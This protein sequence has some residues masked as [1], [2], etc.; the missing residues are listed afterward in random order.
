MRVGVVERLDFGFRVAS[1]SSIG[2]DI[3]WNI[4]QS[5]SFDLAIDPSIQYAH[6]EGGEPGSD[7]LPEWSIDVLRANGVLLFGINA[8]SVTFMPTLGIAYTETAGT[9]GTLTDFQA[10]QTSSGAAARVGLGLNIRVSQKF[11]IQPEFTVL[12]PIERGGDEG[13]IY[14]VGVGFSFGKLPIY[15]QEAAPPATAPG[16]PA[17]A[18]GPA[19]PPATQYPAPA[20]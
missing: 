13:V 17:P 2:A 9:F 11:A 12:R 4:I 16:A 3:K 10:G 7:I 20:Q 14:V 15:E 5:D 19:P 1:F 18:P 8:G 6:L